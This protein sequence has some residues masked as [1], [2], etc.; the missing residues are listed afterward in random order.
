MAP[1]TKKPRLSVNK[2]GEYL[3]AGPARRHRIIYDAKFP[4]DVI[5]PFYTPA[6]EAIAQF[7]AGGMH[8]ISTLENR[9]RTLGQSHAQTVWDQRRINSNIDAIESF[10]NMVDALDLRG[11]TPIL[12]AHKA[13]VVT[14][15]GVDISVR[16][17]ITLEGVGVRGVPIV[18]GLKLHFPKAN[19]LDARA[20][21]Y[22]SAMLHCFSADHLPDKGTADGRLCM[23]V[24]V[25]AGRVYPGS[26]STKQKVRDLQAACAEIASRWPT[27][28][29]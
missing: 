26:I 18:G 12:G 4:S 7:I 2:L 20:G 27:I 10:M 25:S 11:A 28:Q 29:P 17:E 19:P 1:Q 8:D 24:D 14:F 21:G 16:P 6:E 5:V 13:P 15:N 23:L 22:V 3:I 9:I